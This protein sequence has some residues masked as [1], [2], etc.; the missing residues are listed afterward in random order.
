MR[1][2][3]HIVI[4][5]ALFTSC[6]SQQDPKHLDSNDKPNVIHDTVEIVKRT[7][8]TR[9][10]ERPETTTPSDNQ[11]YI[12]ERLPDW[13][14][15]TGLLNG[16]QIGNQYEFDNRLNPL[17]LEADFNGDDNMDIAI[18]IRRTNSGKVG[19][20]IIHGKTNKVYVIGAGKQIKNDNSDNLTFIDIW[21]VNRKKINEPGVGN[22]EP[23]SL[24]N[25]S[26]ELIKSEVGGGQ[27]YWNGSEYVY[28]HQTC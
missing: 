13:F 11:F 8:E 24:D 9:Y 16:L 27:V 19:F 14:L 22:D 1:H 4:A 28:F 25:P 12:E 2:L 10:V 3:L 20:A 6:S 21:K 7:I 15:E 17:Y 18:P 5:A 23:L 26:L